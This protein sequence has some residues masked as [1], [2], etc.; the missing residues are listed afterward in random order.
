MDILVGLSHFSH[1]RIDTSKQD[2]ICAKLLP[3][4]AI[5]FTVAYYTSNIS[6]YLT[7]RV[8]MKLWILNLFFIFY[9]FNIDISLDICTP[10][11]KF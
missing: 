6:L 5:L 8:F 1:L 2:E 4:A 3:F 9:F 10:V 11:M 7:R